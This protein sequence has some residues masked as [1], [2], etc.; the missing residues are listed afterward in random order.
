MYFVYGSSEVDICFRH[1]HAYVK[2][3]LYPDFLTGLLKESYTFF[4]QMIIR[5]KKSYTLENM[6]V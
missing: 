2:K 3:L 1:R 6:L 4:F 5:K